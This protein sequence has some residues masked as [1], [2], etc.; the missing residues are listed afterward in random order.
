MLA[1]RLLSLLSATCIAAVAMA[2]RADE[3]MW[4]PE[5]IGGLDLAHLGSLGLKLRPNQLWNNREGLM[6]AAVNLS[7]CSGAF[8][9]QSGLVATNHHCAYR[10]IQAASTLERDYLTNG[11]L[12]KDHA[13]E[14][15]AQ[16]YTVQVLTGIHDVT[17]QVRAAANTAT[18][19]GP[20]ALAVDK[21]E[22]ELVIAC[23]KQPGHRCT[24]ASFYLGRQYKLFD[25]LELTDVRLVYAP[26]AAVGEFGGEIDNWMWPR[27]AGD[28]ALLRAYVGPDGKP[29]DYSAK[30]VPYAPKEFLKIGA[31]GVGN[32]DFVAVMGYPGKTERYLPASEVARNVDQV[33][34]ATVELAGEWL[35]ILD[36]AAKKNPALAL[37]VAAQQK[38]LA[39][40]AKNARG[41]IAGLARI[42]LVERRQKEEARIK[43]WA[44]D[45]PA[46]KAG[47]AALAALDAL[48]KQERER[49]PRTFLLENL[50]RGP[51]LLGV[52]L[53][54][55]RRAREHTKPDL[56]RR[57]GTM[58][59]DAGRVWKLEERRLADF[60]LDVD[61][62]LLASLAARAHKLPEG[63]AIAALAKLPT[64]SIAGVKAKIRAS[65]LS[66]AKAA[67]ALYDGADSVVLAKS[68]DPMIVLAEALADDLERLDAER[69]A[70]RG[71]M[72]RV[73]PDY[74]TMLEA[75]RGATLYPDANGT[76]RISF[77]TVRGYSPEDGLL[78][79]SRTTLHGAVDKSTGEEPFNL[80]RAVIDKAPEARESYWADPDLD[81]VPVCF[82]SNA[83]TTGGNSGSP[84][85]NGRG[86][87]VG[88]NFDRVWENIAGDFGYSVPRSRNVSVDVRYMLWML[89]RVVD[90]GDLLQELGV[91]R[92]R[93]APSRRERTQPLRRHLPAAPSA[94]STPSPT[95][96]Q[97]S[98][99]SCGCSAPGRHRDARGAS[100]V[101]LLALVAARRRRRATADRS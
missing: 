97:A 30:N 99:K 92:Y 20:R 96:V 1:R 31:Q 8:V 94:S 73:G 74:F 38:Q 101:V 76:L 69:D 61:A 4:T 47:L 33:F 68:R 10:A 84:V 22:H 70:A 51:N 29:A 37:K 67:K 55:V 78:A 72:E 2:A 17:A 36:D 5:Q 45:K 41:M 81:D 53:D 49:F 63:L 62:R 100:A 95:R 88:L 79:V 24:V 32:G 57:P 86:E 6:R 25:T 3:G 75:E 89:D 83:D 34:P 66:D 15:P 7:G 59:R 58:D 13:A 28:F 9:S 52:A 39:N 12:A 48:G 46:G 23:E 50:A 56:E 82:L 64:S 90:A 80:P 93:S 65:H 18:A 54:I 44:A 77:A 85:I 42:K 60:D 27:H 71:A 43:A 21:K 40:R 98:G 19:D 26:P 11:F 91:A 14:L 16:G 35:G 87:L